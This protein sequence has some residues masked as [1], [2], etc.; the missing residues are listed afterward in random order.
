MNASPIVNVEI[1]GLT[2][3]DPPLRQGPLSKASPRHIWTTQERIALRILVESYDD[4][5]NSVVP[6]FIAHFQT[7]ENNWH[8]LSE[9]ILKGQHDWMRCRKSVYHT[10]DIS[11]MV[12]A[13]LLSP[14]SAESVKSSLEAT[15]S[16]LGMRLVRK[17]SKAVPRELRSELP[18]ISYKE[19][20]ILDV[21]VSATAPA[22]TATTPTTPSDRV[23]TG[24]ET[25]PRSERL[26]NR[27]VHSPSYLPKPPIGGTFSKERLLFSSISNKDRSTTQASVSS[28]ELPKLVFR[29]YTCKSQGLNSVNGFRAGVFVNKQH[30]TP[31]PSTNSQ[32]F[33]S[34][35]LRHISADK[36]GPTSFVSITKNPI[37]AI[38]RA[39]R[40]KDSGFLSIIDLTRANEVGSIYVAGSLDVKSTGVHY[41]A[42]GE[43]GSVPSTIIILL[44]AY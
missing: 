37:R 15:A 29:G 16:R 22:P 25:P 33:R 4:G 38:M 19:A 30:V 41:D 12:E 7:A 28:S 39:S 13:S 43:V 31:A 2:T 27:Y 26:S 40:H 5:W 8:G 17:G 9:T 23:A 32:A 44:S 6:V 1:V 11:K 14:E 3:D 24:L 34:D 10:K 21:L 18:V 42:K 35:L 20:T 36:S